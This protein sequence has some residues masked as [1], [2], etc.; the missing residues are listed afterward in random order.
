[1][2]YHLLTPLSENFILFNLFNYITFRAFLSGIIAFLIVFTL[3]PIFI[4]KFKEFRERIKEDVPSWHKKKEGTPTAGGIV[5]LFSVLISSLLLVRYDNPLVWISLFTITYMALIGFYDDYKKMTSKSKVDGLKVLPKLVLQSILAI[6]IF[7]FIIFYYPP[8]IA[9][10][11]QLLFFKNI[12]I[13]FSI[14]YPIFIFFVFVG[15]ANALNLTDG[16]DGLAGSC[17]IPPL[18]TFL[19]VAYIT[20]HIVL[21]KYLN[22]LHIPQAGELTIICSSIIGALLGFLWYNSYPAEIFMGDTGSQMLGG[23]F[24]IIAILIKQE[25]LLAIAGGL[26]VIEALSVIIQVSYFKWTKRKYGQGK[27]IFKR[28]PIHHHFEEIGWQEPKIVARFLIISTLFSI[29]ALATLK[30]R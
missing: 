6:V 18:I 17:S 25:I 22:I 10:K 15:T 26:F 24:G 1:M 5:M 29:L 23:A 7:I 13:D 16:L 30:I 3:T 9:T 20:S 12:Y 19:I 11:T 2:L 4:K 21:S 27:R 28:A 8:Q 14:F